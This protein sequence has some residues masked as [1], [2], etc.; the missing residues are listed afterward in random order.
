MYPQP[1]GAVLEKGN[2]VNPATGLM[3][4]YEELW[5]DLEPSSTEKRQ[6]R[7]SVVLILDDEASGTK[8]MVIRVGEYVQGIIKVNRQITVERWA[9][10]D[11]KDGAKAWTRMV[12]LGDYFLPCSLGFYPEKIALGGEVAF[13]DFKWVVSELYHW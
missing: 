6:E 8:G 9:W 10:E 1:D 7:W 3:T 4:D 12:R 13:G 2:M 11:G 5:T